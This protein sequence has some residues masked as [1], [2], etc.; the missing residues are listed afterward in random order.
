MWGEGRG[1]RLS[2]FAADFLE[3]YEIV[4]EYPEGVSVSTKEAYSNVIPRETMSERLLPLKEVLS[5][6]VGQWK[7]HLVNDFE[8]SVFP[9]YP[10]IAELKRNMYERGA[11]YA[12]MSGSGSALFAL[13][14]K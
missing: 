10:K 13:F 14:E 5:M 6:P 11:V 1:E 2:P 4:V 9:I 3:N 7:Q 8:R 12:S